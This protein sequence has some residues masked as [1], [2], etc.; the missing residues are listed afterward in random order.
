M[1]ETA[2]KQLSATPLNSCVP[3]QMAVPMPHRGRTGESCRDNR[4]EDLNQQQTKSQ[5]SSQQLRL[6]G[7]EAKERMTEK[8]HQGLRL[9][10]KCV[11]C[12]Q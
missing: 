10:G 6:H 12:L 4:D 5:V 7:T 11:C 2:V 1:R 8:A 9:T 3:G